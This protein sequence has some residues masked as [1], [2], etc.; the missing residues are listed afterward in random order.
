MLSTIGKFAAGC[1]AVCLLSGAIQSRSAEPTA[2]QLEFF[3]AKVRPILV[4][5]CFE[6]HNAKLDEPKGGLKVDSHAALLTGGETGPAVV[7][8]NLK[9]SLLIDAIN[10]GELYQMPPKSKLPEAEIAILTKWVE[11]GAP[12]PKEA[13]PAAVA[14]GSPKAFDLQQRKADHWCWQPITDPPLPTVRV[15]GWAKQD[16]DRFIQTRLE[17]ENLSPAP[18]ADKRTLVRRAYFDLIGL[19]PSPQEMSAAIADES[20]EWFAHVVDKLLESPHFGERWGRHWLDLVRYAE[21]R[22]HEFDPN[23]ANAYQYRDY[24]VRALNADLP[25]DQ[26]VAEHIAGD[27]LAEPRKNPTEKFNESIIGTAFWFLGEQV[28]SPVDIRKDE[29]DRFD[30]MVDV[31]GKTFMGVTIACARCHDHKFDAISQKDY[32][33]LF[34]FLQSSGYRLARFDTL[35]EHRQLAQQAADLKAKSLKAIAAA[36]ARSKQAI[37]SRSADYLLAVRDLI[38]SQVLAKM[39]A[40]GNVLPGSLDEAAKAN[41]KS[42]ADVRKLDEVISIRWLGE[43]Q[44]A[45][46]DSTHPLHAWSLICKAPD[47][48]DPQKLGELLTKVYSTPAAP[49]PVAGLQTIVDYDHL[50]A[51]DWLSDGV[52]F[53]LGPIRTGELTLDPLA[54]NPTLAIAAFGS[55]QR[56]PM[57]KGLTLAPNSEQDIGRFSGYTRAGQT[58]RTPTFELR[59]GRVHVQLAGS[60]MIYAAVDSHLI[61]E[62]PLHGQ[63]VRDTGPDTSNT[64]RWFTLDLTAYKGHRLH[65]ELTP[66]GDA[67]FRILRV[68]EGESPPAESPLSPPIALAAIADRP[69][70]EAAAGEYQR[71]IENTLKLIADD[72][73]ASQPDAAAQAALARWLLAR[74]ELL[75]GS[76]PVSQSAAKEAAERAVSYQGEWK[77]LQ[78]SIRKESRL[79]MA[80]WDGDAEDETLLIR[81]NTK[82]VGP[83]VKRGTLEAVST[84]PMELGSGSGRLELARSLLDSRNPLTAR[85][86][87]NRIWH[88]LLGR[89]IVPSTDNFGVLGQEPS[90]PELL[91]HL[92]TR[93]R[94]EGW[95]VKRLIRTIMLS[96]TYQQDSQS[97]PLDNQSADNGQVAV[98][99]EAETRDPQN[100]LFHRQN[101]K[102]LE[103]EAIRDSILAVS[104]RLDRTLQGPSVPVHLTAFMQ[105][106]GRPGTSGPLDGAGRRSVYT[107]VR[108]NFLSPMM[109]AFDTP[110][111]FTT[112]GKRNVSNVP[113]QALI[114]M[115]DPLVLEQS[116]VWAKALLSTANQSPEQRIGS[117]YEQ[118]F[119]REAS[120]SETTA[121]IAFLEEQGREYGLS[122]EQA[123]ADER[124]WADLCHVMYNVKEFVFV[125]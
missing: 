55:A 75:I 7:P 84:G 18:Q 119:G 87:V 44:L 91:D 99:S 4:E 19:P 57:W 12:W 73:V 20:P 72:A 14:S 118:A 24:V 52:A 25:Y 29:T 6:C 95:S 96:S 78:A 114:L 65:L 60:G 80:M 64:V 86:M 76:D 40:Q 116:R 111:P 74:P 36:D 102:R 45:Q 100:V 50:P 106:R 22:G 11:Q 3:E 97:L 21:S 9:D 77:K 104:G 28:H 53:G 94:Q 17:R 92:A 113:A 88:H 59:D 67:N 43:V 71:R 117:I 51:E 103:G 26:F 93:F 110:I 79:T 82:T 63:L 41:I 109:L 98:I 108:R 8:G 61:I 35:D 23:V 15:G 85:V 68:V 124:T 120:A 105:G 66:K 48:N 112:V 16:L 27:L 34:G 38:Q 31:F 123:K 1:M 30:N 49:A 121:A 33:A 69:T 46:A 101:L 13:E 37:A 83:L 47:A 70:L 81:G 32:Y 42:V 5:R 39:D 122:A 125:R 107:S 89:G 10:Y 58:I 56:D 2:E 115:N 90:H 54:S 62:G